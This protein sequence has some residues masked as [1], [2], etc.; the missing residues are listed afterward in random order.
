MAFSIRS[1]PRIYNESLFVSRGIKIVELE[2][3][4][5]FKVTE[6]ETARRQRE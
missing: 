6:P 2:N 5:E 1:D 4:V 3:W